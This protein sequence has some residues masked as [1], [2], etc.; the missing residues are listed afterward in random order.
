VGHHAF[1]SRPSWNCETVQRPLALRAIKPRKLAVAP[2]PFEEDDVDDQAETVELRREAFGIESHV[3][4]KKIDRL[5][6]T[7]S[8]PAI[9]AAPVSRPPDSHVRPRAP[10]SPSFGRIALSDLPAP[11]P[12]GPTLR[13]HPG[14]VVT[15]LVV[16][17]ALCRVVPALV[18]HINGVTGAM[19]N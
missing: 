10:S 5:E 13:L 19:G 7:A 3:R 2:A 4:R 15:V 12:L 9:P 8:M 17:I 6:K 11:I 16:L 14:F 18:A 1:D